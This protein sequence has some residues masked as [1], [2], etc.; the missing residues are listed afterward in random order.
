MSTPEIQLLIPQDRM[1]A[2]ARE[3]IAAA[4]PLEEVRRIRR[5]LMLMM[6]TITSDEGGVLLHV[7]PRH[8]RELCE[9]VG[10][11]IVTLGHKTPRYQV[12]AVVA[13]LEQL[14]VAAKQDKE[15]VRSALTEISARLLKEIE[16][17]NQSPAALA[18]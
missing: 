4:L 6:A 7:T 13:K 14:S 8:F 16:A 3:L 1:E 9:R 10:V 12:A 11:P 15:Q 17:L 18:A 5:E 2:I